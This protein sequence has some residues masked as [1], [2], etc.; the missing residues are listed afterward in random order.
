M[1]TPCCDNN[2]GIQR[3]VTISPFT[4][5]VG[6]TW[7]VYACR[8]NSTRVDEGRKRR[9]NPSRDENTR[10]KASHIVGVG[11]GGGLSDKI[12]R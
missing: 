7:C 8:R 11:R 10:I 1:L 4:I 2:E 3:S 5:S 12:L 6:H 9:T